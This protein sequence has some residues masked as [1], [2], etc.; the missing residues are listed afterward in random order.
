MTFFKAGG[1]WKSPNVTGES[2]NSEEARQS[3]LG[4]TIAVVSNTIQIS[5]A[6]VVGCCLL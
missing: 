2:E 5:A 6:A 1:F 3:I 4:T